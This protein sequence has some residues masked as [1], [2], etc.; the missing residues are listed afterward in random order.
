MVRV[1]IR[2]HA[3]NGY[4]G[5]QAPRGGL[6]RRTKGA[7]QSKAHVKGA[8]AKASRAHSIHYTWGP[9]RGQAL[10]GWAPPSR[11]AAGASAP[12]TWVRWAGCG[13][14]HAARRSVLVDAEYAHSVHAAHLGNGQHHHHLHGAGKG[15]VE[16]QDG[17]CCGHTA[18]MACA[19]P[20]RVTQAAEQAANHHCKATSGSS[21]PPTKA[22]VIVHSTSRRTRRLR[23][24]G[25]RRKSVPWEASRKSRTWGEQTGGAPQVSAG[26]ALGVVAELAVRAAGR[27]GSKASQAGARL[28][29]Q[30]HRPGRGATGHRVQHPSLPCPLRLQGSPARL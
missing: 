10:L 21:L 26:A 24:S 16:A 22:K 17:T 13:C 30:Q 25:C 11:C 29:G 5:R 6:C 28:A 1:W 9:G 8:G 2:S 20:L 7:T 19:L 23:P 3:T 12:S 15:G 18:G 4:G 14:C 27:Q